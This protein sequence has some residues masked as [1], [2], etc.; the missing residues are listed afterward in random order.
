ML[1]IKEII[2]K[3]PDISAYLLLAVLCWIFLIWGI[4]FYPLLDVDETRYA[5][6]S[7]DMAYSN[8][9]NTLVLN[10]VPFLEK[11]PFYFWLV[12]FSI[13][14]FGNFSNMA[15]RIPI[16]FLST[17]FIFATYAFGKKVISRKF[18]LF[19]SITL[20]T[21][22]F[23]LIFAHVAILDIILTIW[24]A[25]SLYCAYLSHIVTDKYKK[26][27]WWGFWTFAG[28]GF[29]AKG[30]LAIAIPFV[31][32]FLYCF[33]TK[34][35]KDMFKP[36][37]FL[38][39]FLVFLLIILPWHIAMYR[40][41]DKMFIHEYFIKHH[42]A[43]LINSNE[44]GRKHSLFYFIPVFLIAFLPWTIIF[45][46]AVYNQCKEL[47]SRF[48]HSTGNIYNKILCACYPKNENEKMLLFSLIYFVVVFGVMSI[49][50]TKLP[51]YILPA[52]PP[53]AFITGYFWCKSYED[54]KY[55]KIISVSTNILAAI[56]ILAGLF[57]AIGFIFFPSKVIEILNPFKYP[58]L[59]GCCFVGMLM[60]IKLKSKHLV[61]I[62]SGYVITMFFVITFAVTNLFTILYSGG[63]D[64]LILYSNYANTINTRLV[65]F[66]FA[67][68][69]ST[70]IYYNDY[71]DY[72]TDRD[73][74]K[75]ESIVSNK[76]VPVF[77]IVKNKEV[78]NG[79]YAKELAK[80]L[81]PVRVGKKYSLM[82]NIK[83]PN[84]TKLYPILDIK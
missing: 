68:K 71:V 51:S 44:I 64:E 36:L 80:Y 28:M 35:L 49:S 70:K 13:K 65:T 41:F 9:W 61:S 10:S 75:L 48:K 55:K 30:I 21:S 46:S 23:F 67:V 57:T 78:K 18:G 84:K 15:V 1:K 7:R 17:F 74:K 29:L 19:S 77:V 31:I 22:V 59:L 33:L 72:I 66:D 69:P 62:F 39:G 37:H 63:E 12:G 20:L 24:I 11:P 47:Y 52:I 3:H 58:V 5:I 73:F 25:C 40:D 32:M 38:V 45:L 83:M 6:M 60:I 34:T 42:F 43:R 26:Y 54:D 79:N 16:A 4:N 50:S 81:Y 53:A 76:N 56:F 8:D 27:C 82:F 2:S 14:L